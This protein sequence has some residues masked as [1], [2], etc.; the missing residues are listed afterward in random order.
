MYLKCSQFKI[1]AGATYLGF[2]LPVI[3]ILRLKAFHMYL[4]ISNIESSHNVAIF[5]IFEGEQQ[6]KT[7]M[8]E[9]VLMYCVN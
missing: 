1:V 7:N 4:T 9:I 2:V 6:C 5:C 3:Q 8:L